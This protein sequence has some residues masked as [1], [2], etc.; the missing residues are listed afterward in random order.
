MVGILLHE[1]SQLAVHKHRMH[2]RRIELPAILRAVKLCKA[3]VVAL[4]T[5]ERL[6]VLDDAD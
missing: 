5:G 3:E 4:G 6:A 2:C 1:H